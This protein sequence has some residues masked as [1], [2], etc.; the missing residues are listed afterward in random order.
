MSLLNSAKNYFIIEMHIILMLFIVHFIKSGRTTDLNITPPLILNPF[1]KYQN[2]KGKSIF[3][4]IRTWK[5]KLAHWIW[6]DISFSNY[7][8]VFFIAVLF[9][10]PHCLNNVGSCFIDISSLPCTSV[11]SFLLLSRRIPTRWSCN[12]RFLLFM[13]ITRNGHEPIWKAM[14]ILTIQIHSC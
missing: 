11:F 7:E 4:V 10:S 12:N 14:F 1:L 5:M 9:F 2:L 8:W 6:I 13:I 3:R